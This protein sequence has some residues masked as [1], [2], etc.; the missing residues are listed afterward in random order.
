MILDFSNQYN[1]DI[2]RLKKRK[3][4]LNKLKEVHQHILYQAF[5]N[6]HRDH[7]LKGNFKGYRGCHVTSD[8]VVV[9][10][11]INKNHIELHR[12]GTHQDVFKQ[13]Y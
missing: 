6:R 12:T 11:F 8:W 5:E 7:P 9:Y 13:N 4:N 1:K 10:R 2:K 3:Y